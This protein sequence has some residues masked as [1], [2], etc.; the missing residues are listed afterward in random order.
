MPINY[1][2]L[3]SQFGGASAP[4]QED[5]EQAAPSSGMGLLGKGI[6]FFGEL[7]GLPKKGTDYAFSAMANPAL[8]LAGQEPVSGMGDFMT[9][10]PLLGAT[11]NPIAGGVNLVNQA[12]ARGLS[13][14]GQPKAAGL[15][16]GANEASME[17][18]TDPAM[19]APGLPGK[20]G[21]ILQWGFRA[22]VGKGMLDAAQEYQKEME[23]KTELTP[24]AMEI[25]GSG[26]VML[27]AFLGGEAGH[28]SHKQGPTAGEEVRTQQQ[29]SRIPLIK[30]G[31]PTDQSISKPPALNSLED[32][33]LDAEL[34]EGLPRPELTPEQMAPP[35]PVPPNHPITGKVMGVMNS[36][37]QQ[38]NSALAQ[39]YA[40]AQA[41]T[42]GPGDFFYPGEKPP[43]PVEV[44]YSDA[45]QPGLATATTTNGVY[46][47]I[48]ES[49]PKII[50]SPTGVGSLLQA[51][52]AAGLQARAIRLVS[53]EFAHFLNK[54]KARPGT[55]DPTTGL[56]G[57]PV[58]QN[59]HGHSRSGEFFDDRTQDISDV[60]TTR[61]LESLLKGLESTRVQGELIGGDPELA[62]NLRGE[63]PQAVEAGTY[64]PETLGLIEGLGIGGT[65]KGTPY[66]LQDRGK[67][68][69][70]AA[71][72]EALKARMEGRRA[73]AARG[74]D[75]LDPARAAQL[76]LFR[77]RMEAGAQ[78][79]VYKP[80]R[81]QAA[82]EDRRLKLLA[83]QRAELEGKMQGPPATDPL[84]K[85]PVYQ[86]LLGNPKLGQEAA[87]RWR[88]SQSRA[89]EE[90]IPM[91]S[92]LSPVENLKTWAST[93]KERL[94]SAENVGR[95]NK[96]GEAAF[97][98]DEVADHMKALA[99]EIAIK[100]GEAVKPEDFGMDKALW[101]RTLA[102]FRAQAHQLAGKG[103]SPQLA[104]LNDTIKAMS[105]VTNAKP[106]VWGGPRDQRE[107]GTNPRAQGT[108]PKALGDRYTPEQ[109]AA[110]REKQHSIALAMDKEKVPSSIQALND[111][112]SRA[113]RMSN[114]TEKLSIFRRIM[115]TVEQVL[116]SANAT[117][118]QKQHATRVAEASAR[119]A[120]KAGV[121]SIRQETRARV[122]EK[123]PTVAAK[124]KSS[125]LDEFP[126][127]QVEGAVTGEAPVKKPTQAGPRIAGRRAGAALTPEE[128]RQL[129][130]ARRRILSPQEQIDI[131][132]A[133]ASG[134]KEALAEYIKPAKPAP[135]KP[136][137]KMDVK[138]IWE[139]AQALR[140]RFTPKGLLP[141]GAPPER[142]P[143]DR[144]AL[145]KEIESLRDQIAATAPRPAFGG[146]TEAHRHLERKRI[147]QARIM[148]KSAKAAQ[149]NAAKEGKP[150][151]QPKLTPVPEGFTP[152]RVQKT[153][154]AERAVIKR[155]KVEIKAVDIPVPSP[156]VVPTE[157]RTRDWT[158]KDGS[159][160]KERLLS[161]V[162]LDAAQIPGMR[163][164][165][166]EYARLRGLKS[167][168]ELGTVM[169][170]AGKK[171]SELDATRLVY[172]DAVEK[173]YKNN[174]AAQAEVQKAYERIGGAERYEKANL[175][176]VEEFWSD[177]KP[178]Q[179][180]KPMTPPPAGASPERSQIAL[181]GKP[182][183]QGPVD[184]RPSKAE[185]AKKGQA[186][187][188]REQLTKKT[189]DMNPN[190]YPG[191]VFPQKYEGAIGM[192][193]GKGG[194]QA[195]L[196]PTLDPALPMR[197][198][199]HPERKGKRTGEAETA[200]RFRWMDRNEKVGNEIELRPDELLGSEVESQ[201]VDSA[202]LNKRYQRNAAMQQAEA[203]RAASDI[204]SS[205]KTL[206]GREKYASLTPEERKTLKGLKE[207]EGDALGMQPPPP[208]LGFGKKADALLEKVSADARSDT[209]ATPET[210][211]LVKE[212]VKR[213]PTSLTA[214]KIIDGQ[215]NLGELPKAQRAAAYMEAIHQ[216]ALQHRSAGER[217][218]KPFPGKSA[219]AAI[220]KAKRLE[221]ED[222]LKATRPN[223]RKGIEPAH[224]TRSKAIASW[225][226]SAFNVS[227]T[228][229]TIADLSNPLRQTWM[230]TM[231]QAFRDPK[232]WRKDNQLRK[233]L[234]DMVA[235]WKKAG[236]EQL[237]KEMTDDPD[238]KLAKEAGVNFTG[239]GTA[240]QEA[241]FGKQPLVQALKLGQK[242]PGVK[243][244]AKF[245]ESVVE[246]SE[247]SYTYYQDR[248][249]LDAFKHAMNYVELSSS[250]APHEAVREIAHMI[251]NAA[252]RGQGFVS[253]DAAKY[254]NLMVFSQ[255]MQSSRLRM[256]KNAMTGFNNY[257][258]PEAKAYARGTALR[259]VAANLALVGSL[260]ALATLAGEEPEVDLD[261]RSSN[262]AKIKLGNTVVDT[263][264]SFQQPIRTAFQVITGS[265]KEVS[266]GKVVPKNPAVTLMRFAR[267]KM[268]PGGGMLY[269]AIT[270]QRSPS[271]KAPKA[272]ENWDE[273]QQ[274]ARDILSPLSVED[275][276]NITKENPKHLALIPMMLLGTGVSAGLGSK[277]DW[278]TGATREQTTKLAKE[279]RR[280]GVG[281]PRLGV[282]V[283]LPGKDKFGKRLYYTASARELADHD[284]LYMPLITKVLSEFIESPSYKAK[285]TEQQRKALAMRIAKLNEVYGVNRRMKRQVVQNWK[286]GKIQPVNKDV[287]EK[288][289]TFGG[290][291][292]KLPALKGFLKSD[293]EEEVK[294]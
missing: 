178:G 283:S 278:A 76:G 197:M 46:F 281:D 54:N 211:A 55:I 212:I 203:E 246:G 250:K 72:V 133:L 107:Q 48:D 49:G 124:Q 143:I 98:A 79:G 252:S 286:A 134:D 153:R 159:V 128:A 290:A 95:H 97:S 40:R 121:K 140:E 238:W 282:N 136:R 14:M 260:T 165:F 112:R 170:E 26:G 42:E 82:I 32:T 147:R 123:K 92:P 19:I 45:P 150:S 162:D 186:P 232:V 249:M 122:R 78:A 247:R 274:T 10:H 131:S 163:K 231:D 65:E 66:N 127:E 52:D 271:G 235:S 61:K 182:N 275:F 80:E 63:T 34:V 87:E 106:R 43:Q 146:S 67:D 288:T 109:K 7:A 111:A 13:A 273:A 156:S 187:V 125:I 31:R 102:N 215:V 248:A 228:M 73:G 292:L 91:E 207:A 39:D 85:H 172:E 171:F 192:P 230:L 68:G 120:A 114:P 41:Q 267:S 116:G 241:F 119:D 226:G 270:G 138:G 255:Q 129:R 33:S 265:E 209:K 145:I 280:L 227:T 47:T 81:V 144:A 20:A 277:E 234:G 268:S 191:G 224:V 237:R 205:M 222:A 208:R 59:P 253:G 101:Q 23:G 167:I 185:G 254:V 22:L 142:K 126:M 245:L 69:Q 62:S 17:M 225:L 198:R 132:K 173:G 139:R 51:G 16:K 210:V 201:F 169:P 194:N 195:T 152:L 285:T 240:Q 44:V 258:T 293:L 259:A 117:E 272:P 37:A 202:I 217:Q 38:L 262:F 89:V 157:T 160:V 214:I 261:P 60:Y 15:V 94:A 219:G 269:D 99:E 8:R 206:Q 166:K 244:P 12:A 155:G 190:E 24:R 199:T 36:L 196:P 154:K 151:G 179:P 176:Q 213:Y 86:A 130:M 175:K 28:A 110:Y 149:E 289:L 284:K 84:L 104:K 141:A 233:N 164:T 83:E 291:K 115:D 2:L 239:E 243:H 71:L 204:S 4:P 236:G 50:M 188:R 57:T 218:M 53:H 21:N 158:A 9:K 256:I 58:D 56:E 220:P 100:G 74:E 223:P 118:A 75:K 25:L 216:I 105:S 177:L 193:S 161:K 276:I 108:N 264:A 263:W 30:N 70:P 11:I 180:S 174:P 113:N 229:K 184:L 168:T 88:A 35:E 18:A 287:R 266:T 294:D 3:K 183:V 64:S 5:P 148:A 257:T 200:R 1:D 93:L 103:P 189:Y 27:G 181:Y 242:L 137:P 135:G 96:R 90:P 221:L 77:K 29:R 6:D 279:Q 251:N